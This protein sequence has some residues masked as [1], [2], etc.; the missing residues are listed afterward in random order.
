M[1]RVNTNRHLVP[2][3]GF[4]HAVLVDPGLPLVFVSGLTA[5]GPDGT[6]L[7][8]GDLAGQVNVVFDALSDV[9][10]RAGTRIER[11][12]SLRVYLLEPRE[13]P[14]VEQAYRRLW[15][16]GWPASTCIGTP[17]LVHPDQLIEVEAIANVAPDDRS[18]Q[19]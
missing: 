4:T 5:R 9:L 17:R 3:P 13:W 11:V 19:P 8:P 12:I 6:V 18:A 1:K 10:A 2:G 7:Y 14:V 16:E 15:P